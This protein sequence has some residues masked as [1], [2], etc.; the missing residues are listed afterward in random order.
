MDPGHDA[1]HPPNQD[2]E[3]KSGAY[4]DWTQ[5]SGGMICTIACRF[6]VLLMSPV[7]SANTSITVH[8]SVFGGSETHSI[9]TTV[10]TA[11][12]GYEYFWIYKDAGRFL[13]ETGNWTCYSGFWAY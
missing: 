2:V 11:N 9:N 6:F 5:P 10:G 1:G 12:N 3:V 4:I 13:Y 7:T 8:W